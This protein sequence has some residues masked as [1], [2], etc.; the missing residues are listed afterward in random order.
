[1]NDDI[2]VRAEGLGK[3]Y[4]L[5]RTSTSLREVVG[6]AI[7]RPLHAMRPN[8]KPYIPPFQPFWALRDATF[9]VRRGEVLGIIGRNGSGKSTLLKILARITKPTT[10]HAEI[11][12]RQG[13]ILEVGSGFHPELTGRENTYLNGSVLGMK[14]SEI[15]EKFDSIVEFAEIEQF[16]D[17]PVKFYSSGMY[18]RLAFSVAAHLDA[19]VLLIDEVLAVGDLGFIQKSIQKMASLAREGRTVLLVNHM[20]D[21]MLPICT[22][23]M[24]VKNGVVAHMG[25]PEEMIDLYKQHLFAPK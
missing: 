19:E 7:A 8:A 12:G 13:V 22:R 4:Y 3:R 10:G 11:R 20:V 23:I 5:R 6:Y 25:D 18:V 2:V 15:T 9:E 24:F 14:R 17:I 16:I 1:M 21:L